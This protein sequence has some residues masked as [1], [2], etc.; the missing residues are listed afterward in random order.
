MVLRSQLLALGAVMLATIGAGGTAAA[1]P[2]PELLVSVSASGG[3]C[4]ARVCRW[5]ARITTTTVVAEGRQSRRL[6]LPER[7]ALT[8]AIA[9]IH[10][11]SL[12]KFT[13]TCP[14]AYDGQELTYRFRGKRALRSCTYDL[15]GV[16]AVLLVD[17]L[18]ASLPAR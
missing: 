8:G 18:L 1:A 13:G 3:H 16:R 2:R 12:P 6:T 7:R 15:R 4:P 14:I 10:P 11:S 5:T 9:E 17:R